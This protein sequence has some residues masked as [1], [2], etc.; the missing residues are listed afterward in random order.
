VKSFDILTCP[1]Q[2]SRLI[3]ASAGTGKTYTI[4]GLFLRL[5][6]EEGIAVSRI[7][8]VTFTVAA[9]EELKERIRKTLRR[10]ISLLADEDTAETDPLL[11]A[12]A[13]RYREDRGALGRLQSALRNFDEAAIYTIHGFCQQMLFENAFESNSTFDT[14]LIT[15]ERELLQEVIDDFWRQNFYRLPEK[16][17]RYVMQEISIGDLFK[18]LVKRSIDPDF[19]ILPRELPDESVVINALESLRDAYGDMC[20]VWNES[21]DE[22]RK[23]LL[24]HRGLDGR[25]YRKNLLEKWLD[26]IALYVRSDDPLGTSPLERFSQERLRESTK[27]DCMPP[28]HEFF[29]CCE[30]L[31]EKREE[32]LALIDQYILGLKSTL[33]DFADRELG[34]RK[35][36]KNARS[37]DDLLIHLHEALGEGED[38]ALA[39]SARKRFSAALIDEFQ[40][41]DPV[42]YNIFTTLFGRDDSAL[43]LI[44]DPK[45]AIFG[46][47]GA[48][49]FSYLKASLSVTDRY[50]LQMNWRSDEGLISAFNTLFK[51][52]HR[53]FI[54]E[55][56][57][58]VPVSAAPR[59]GRVFS[60]TDNG[61]P[62][63]IWFLDS[64]LADNRDGISINKSTAERFIS[65][66]VASEISRLIR[67]GT[68]RIDDKPLEPGDIAVLVRTHR[69]AR[70]VQDH[71][72][73][74]SVPSV[75]QGA[76]SVF[77][78]REALEL[79]RVML[80]VAEPGNE[81]L[82]RTALATDIFGYS[83]EQLLLR[84]NDDPDGDLL[85]DRMYRYHN[86]WVQHG[87]M[88]MFRSLLTNEGVRFRLLSFIDGERRMTNLLH[89][90]ELLHCAEVEQK[91]GMESLITWLSVRRE[92][93]VKEEELRLE[94]DDDAV[95]IV[96]VHSSK[97]LE[98]PVV[99]CPF[100]WSGRAPDRSGFTFHDPKRAYNLTLD[101]RSQDEENWKCAEREDLAENIRL[102][103]VAITRARHRCYLFWGKINNTGTSAPAYLFHQPE[104]AGEDPVA[105][106]RNEMISRDP[107]MMIRDL[108]KI[109][110]KSQNSIAVKVFSSIPEERSLPRPRLYDEISCRR[111]TGT[112]RRDWKISSY[113]SL[114]YRREESEPDYDR[115][116][117]I[118]PP[119]GGTGD[120]FGFPRGA[121]AG[122]CI[123]EIF[124]GIDFT[125]SAREEWSELINSRL[126]RY[127][128][129]QKWRNPL[130]AMIERVLDTRLGDRGDFSLRSVGNG[131]RLNEL[132]FHFPL[133]S[134]A[135]P[136]LITLISHYSERFAQRLKKL[137]I[138]PARGFVRGFIDMVFRQGDRYH[139]VD[140]KSNHLG[141]SIEDYSREALQSA[142]EEHY[143]ILQ[144]HLYAVALHRYLS[145]RISD[146]DYE[147]HFGDIFYIFIRGVDPASGPAYGIY[148]ERPSAALISAL[149]E[150][151]GEG[152]DE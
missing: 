97:G 54:F 102:L 94:T 21:G 144:Y 57:G 3:E 65:R 30:L 71:L 66:A 108:E 51:R 138:L 129:E 126:R 140:W 86:L 58:Y 17:A 24:S 98:Y 87:F 48:D 46:F 69:Q 151:L 53:P 112:I 31:H 146:Y 88:R 83:G 109:A 64:G 127:G 117:A 12:L 81:S 147:K 42:Q 27:A 8:V 59:E 14:V 80:A 73:K 33:F 132:E 77:S 4:A 125:N 45:Q 135:V 19:Q 122:Q 123:H 29:Y 130:L 75:L 150:S 37:F 76:E 34:R 145:V 18:L 44:G 93:P 1:L 90:S 11:I 141:G 107:E 10:V 63:Q 61:S 115:A 131:D 143:Y 136:K 15:D 25:R 113:S 47:R 50:T 9:T 49:I 74:L 22:I 120:I 26:Q 119:G 70:M 85:L 67:A 62:F 36:E 124:E 35:S 149:S 111:F 41:T 55:E 114:I 20:R 79:E 40:D 95:Q 99:F 43:F 105:E 139:I 23:V 91:Q 68:A 13:E 104:R 39:R 103:Y 6:L 106:L 60:I 7:L 110:E 92:S 142:M 148:S 118:T 128:F 121:Q 16:L 78:A 32:S 96:T 2:G 134:D 116:L 89:L 56:I 38:S 72:R 100:A 28:E 5:I 101:L 84:N 52:L 82:L 137:A 133:G 152:A